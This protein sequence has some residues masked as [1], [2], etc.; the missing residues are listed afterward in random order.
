MWGGEDGFEGREERLL[1]LL[2]TGLEE[3]GRLEEDRRRKARAETGRE[4][5]DCFGCCG[6]E[7]L[8]KVPV[9]CRCHAYMWRCPS[10]RAQ[11]MRCSTWC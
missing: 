5:K 8:A 9:L 11:L 1:G 3:I 4:V 7:L 2:D 6:V 10:S